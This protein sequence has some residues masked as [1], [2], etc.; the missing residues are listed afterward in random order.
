VEFKGAELALDD[1][2]KMEEITEKVRMQLGNSL[3]VE[4]AA[5]CLTAT[6]F[7][8]EL[9]SIPTKYGEYHQGVGYI[10]CRLPCKS[11][12]RQELMRQLKDGSARFLLDGWPATKRLDWSASDVD[13]IFRKRIEFKVKAGIAITLKWEG[14][15]ARHISGSLFSVEALINTQGLNA[16]FGRAD[17]KK[18]KRGEDIEERRQKRRRVRL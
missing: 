18:R 9:E 11:A 3:K 14:F 2:L 12:S 16:H 10:Y 6:R 1:V 7:Y 15:Q 5:Q 13:G 8:F 4:A 17:H